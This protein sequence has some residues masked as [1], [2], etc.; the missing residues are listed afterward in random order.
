MLSIK[1][2]NLKNT[3]RKY[4]WIFFVLEQKSILK[5]YIKG[6]NKTNLEKYLSGD[7]TALNKIIG[8]EQNGKSTA[9]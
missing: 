1:K 4:R 9:T 8:K 6:R 2:L 3:K 7:N 5:Q